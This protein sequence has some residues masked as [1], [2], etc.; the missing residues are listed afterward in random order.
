MTYADFAKLMQRLGTGTYDGVTGY[1]GTTIV[2][3]EPD[4]SG[5]AQQA[6]LS[7]P[8]CYGYCS[9]TGNDPNLLHAS[10]ASSGVAD[11]A[12]YANTWR[13][14]NLALLHLRDLYAPNVKLAFHVSNWAT[15]RDIGSDTDPNLDPVA[16]GNLAGSFAA[17]S[18]VSDAPAGTSTYDLVFNDVSDRDAGYYKYVVGRPHTFWD[19]LNVSL[20][21]FVRWERYLGAITAT[22]GRTA[23]VWQV[24]LGNQ[25]AASENNTDGHYQDNRAEYFF[26]HVERAPR[27]WASSACC[28]AAA[29]AAARPTPTT[30]ATGSPTPRPSARRTARAAARSAPTIRQ[31]LRTTTAATC[32]PPP[33]R[34]TRRLSPSADARSAFAYQT[35]VAL[36]RRRDTRRRPTG[37]SPAH[38]CSKCATS[39]TDRRVARPNLSPIVCAT[40]ISATCVTSS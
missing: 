9:G 38:H 19:R 11:V 35:L 6:V 12:A 1:G 2:Q 27:T 29:T 28:S 24:P 22:T 15:W 23:M 31:R 25:W 16:Q 5:Y 30:R 37:R 21:N 8:A 3:V 14:F 26:G 34:T 13:G 33:R 32:G 7:A 4:L 18:G 36:A 10:V 20:P 39:S 17:A 40:G